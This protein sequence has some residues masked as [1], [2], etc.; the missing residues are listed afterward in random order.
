MTDP[1]PWKDGMSNHVHLSKCSGCD[2]CDYLI[3]GFYMSCDGCGHW[4]HQDSDGWVLRNG[5]PFC[6]DDCA[7]RYFAH[8]AIFQKETQ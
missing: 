1:D 7:D 3:D 5:V 2:R 6:T 8:S 4:G